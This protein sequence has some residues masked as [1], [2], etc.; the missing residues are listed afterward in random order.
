M[1]AI[2]SMSAAIRM[3]TGLG[4]HAPVVAAPQLDHFCAGDLHRLELGDGE[5]DEAVA[6]LAD[7]AL[8]VLEVLDDG[9]GLLGA[10]GTDNGHLQHAPMVARPPDG[11]AVLQRLLRGGFANHGDAKPPWDAISR[12]CPPGRS[13]DMSAIRWTA[14]DSPIGRLT[15]VAS[16]EGLVALGFER[17]QVPAKATKAPMPEVTEQIDAYFAGELRQFDLSL[18]LRGT[19]LERAVWQGLLEI[20]YGETATYG[21]QAARIEPSLFDSDIETWQRARAV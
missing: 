6:P 8:D 3:F 5:D 15:L 16:E 4:G 14:H 19:P 17:P 10:A 18:D 21:Q 11:K 13:V 9:L 7:L 12:F 20:P 1:P 2:P